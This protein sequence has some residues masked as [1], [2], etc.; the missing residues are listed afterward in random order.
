MRLFNSNREEL[1]CIETKK[2]PKKEPLYSEFF[3]NFFD[4]VEN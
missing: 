4:F 1:K 3:S 2:H